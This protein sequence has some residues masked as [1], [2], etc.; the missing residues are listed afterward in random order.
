[1]IDNTASV[2][3]QEDK[4]DFIELLTKKPID[5]SPNTAFYSRDEA[6]ER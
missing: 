6:N 2:P 5:I 3:K 4:H 1:M